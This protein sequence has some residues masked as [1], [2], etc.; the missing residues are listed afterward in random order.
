MDCLAARSRYIIASV[1][2]DLL[3]LLV[4]LKDR[5]H[6]TLVIG[7]ER[8]DVIDPFKKNWRITSILL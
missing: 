4:V 8:G 5:D 2:L 1:A 3:L 6:D 7:S